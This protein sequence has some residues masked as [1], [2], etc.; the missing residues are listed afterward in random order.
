MMEALRYQP[1]MKP[2]WDAFVEASK[3]GTFLLKRDYM[4][5]HSDRFTD[6]SLMFYEGENL[7][8]LFPAS[9]HGKRVVSHGGLTYGGLIVDRSMTVGTMLDVM[10][11]LLS[12]LRGGGMEELAYKRIPSI[13]CSYPSD[14]DLYALFRNGAILSKCGI[15]SAIYLPERIRFSERRRRAVNKAKRFGLTIQEST[16]FEGFLK[17]LSDVLSQ[18]HGV[19]PV[20]TAP[21]LRLLQS[22]FPENIKLYVALKENRIL[23]GTVVYITPQVVHTQYLANSE[24]GRIC[25]AL[26]FVIDNL[27]SDVY[28]DKRYFDFGISTEDGGHYLN[29]GLA[30]QKQEFGARGIVYEEFSV[31]L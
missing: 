3:N 30:V 8:A 2:F 12:F 13:Y 21:E 10:G 5:Y 19:S 18:R 25:G 17:V 31:R 16:D 29:E 24:E 22:L 11:T 1:S 9:L 7:K 20:H 23:A 27:V 6:C 4:E 15:S 14:E 26:D 28:K